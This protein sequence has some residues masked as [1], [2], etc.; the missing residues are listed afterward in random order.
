[1]S[2]WKLSRDSDIEPRIGRDWR[3][4]HGPA[5]RL[6]VSANAGENEQV[7]EVHSPKNEQGH[8]DFVAE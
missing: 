1:M 2:T 5:R 8:S 4:R 3:R 7:E 6:G